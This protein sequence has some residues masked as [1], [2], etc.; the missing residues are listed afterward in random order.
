MSVRSLRDICLENTGKYFHFYDINNQ[1]INYCPKDILRDLI[2]Y[3]NIKDLDLI[4][5][6]LGDEFKINFNNI[7][8][9][10][11]KLIWQQP[12]LINE[13]LTRLQTHEELL[14]FKNRY[15]EQLFIS[16]RCMEIELCVQFDA[17]I[18]KRLLDLSL[19][20]LEKFNIE[21]ERIEFKP[22]IYRNLFLNRERWNNKWNKY[23]RKL[24]FVQTTWNI[25]RSDVTLINSFLETVNTLI[26]S[27]YPQSN[28]IQALQYI[29]RLLTCGN[30]Y[31]L[32][33][34]FPHR[35][36]LKAIILLMCNIGE[37]EVC[38]TCDELR[39][40]STTTVCLRNETLKNRNYVSSGYLRTLRRGVCRF[41]HL[42]PQNLSPLVRLRP[43]SNDSVS[44]TTLSFNN[45][46]NLIDSLR[47]SSSDNE[48]IDT[49]LPT[50]DEEKTHSNESKIIF[51]A[52]I[53]NQVKYLKTLE[54][55]YVHKITNIELI[56]QSLLAMKYLENLSLSYINPYCP[57]L[58]HNLVKLVKENR[59]KSLSMTNLRFSYGAAGFIC[60]ILA[61]SN[62]D[63]LLNRHLEPLKLEYLKLEM[64]KTQK[65]DFDYPISLVFSRKSFLK[66][67]K[68]KDTHFT[69]IQMQILEKTLCQSQNIECLELKSI[70]ISDHVS[71]CLTQILNNCKSLKEL[72][73][74]CFNFQSNV[75]LLLKLL[76][77]NQLIK[78]HVENGSLYFN[79][80]S[81]QLLEK[82]LLNCT[83]LKTLN[84]PYNHLT[85]NTI[86]SIANTIRISHQQNLFLPEF[87]DFSH[88]NLQYESI[89]YFCETIFDIIRFGRI[90]FKTLRFSANNFDSYL[91]ETIKKK[92]NSFYINAEF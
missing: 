19:F 52:P 76:G 39:R 79:E 38:F 4:E 57:L 73:F 51:S 28:D 1:I 56:S 86:I 12:Y 92:L 69:R 58:E 42:R 82:T 31:N 74:D 25:M 71:T 5:D 24:S 47:Q 13:S 85:N 61:H 17:N 10:H 18:Y 80:S 27:G 20:T 3:L 83:K 75:D 15:F 65:Y 30:V 41:G 66:T 53:D 45:N 55:Y 64:I 34:K 37:K 72:R 16:S 48:N 54:L 62:V 23:I 70:Q 2:K 49:K 91:F 77:K 14:P 8:K 89:F 63:T 21:K 84:F 22:L 32:V 59:L 29:V 35:L 36:V 50:I 6:Y 88:N 68:W 11:Y 40:N 9:T 7:W 67:L 43:F 60:Q 46:N 44:N 87:I 78:I 26:L 90:Y 33:I 81:N